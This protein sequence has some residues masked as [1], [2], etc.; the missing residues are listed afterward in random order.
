M[1]IKAGKTKNDGNGKH[2]NECLVKKKQGNYANRALTLNVARN[3]IA[4]KI[5]RHP[6]YLCDGFKRLAI[7][8][9]IELEC[10][11]VLQLHA[12]ALRTSM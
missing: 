8:E 4:C 11:V 3:C 10:E 7:P 5:G 12:F 1:R 6:L 9:R 2:A